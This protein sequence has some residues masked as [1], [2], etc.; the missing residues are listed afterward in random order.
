MPSAPVSL[1]LSDI[2]GNKASAAAPLAER[3]EP[4]A[5]QPEPVVEQPAG[6]SIEPVN[7]SEQNI[8]PSG[9][10]LPQ[11]KTEETR[12]VEQQPRQMVKGEVYVDEHG[13][14]IFGE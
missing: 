13:N 1:A 11:Q 3:P 6:V 7:E 14:V 2:T 5:E 4:I 9:L 12:P 10:I 8:S